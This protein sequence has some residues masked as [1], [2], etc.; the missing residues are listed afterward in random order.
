MACYLFIHGNRHGKWAW[1]QV[2]DLL[3]RRGHRAHAIDLP[4]H[5]NDT[6]P[7]HTAND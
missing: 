2:V 4:G 7:R 6:T 5:G 1:A 3:E